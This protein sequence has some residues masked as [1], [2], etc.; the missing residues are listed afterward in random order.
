MRRWPIFL[1]LVLLVTAAVAADVQLKDNTVLVKRGPAVITYRDFKA[2]LNRLPEGVRKTVADDPERLSTLLNNLVKERLVAEQARKSRLDRDP[3]VQAALGLAADRVLA[4]AQM[5]KVVREGK[6]ADYESMAREY[7]LAHPDEFKE[8]ERIDVSHILIDTDDRTDEQA[9]ERAEEVLHK[10]KSGE[11]S[12]E[13]LVEQY[14]DEPSAK[15][16]HG[17]FKGVKRGKFVKPFENAAFALDKPG[18]ITGPVKTRFGYHLIRL[19]G[20]TPPGEQSFE[21]AKPA[22][23]KR[24]REKQEDRIRGQYIDRLIDANPLEADE[25]TIR[26]LRDQ[27]R[28]HIPP[29][30]K[31]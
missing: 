17:H 22:L 27:Y 31:Q 9:R 20:R 28:H 15:D 5:A 26:A 1:A 18:D 25:A 23:V 4:Q 7:Y 29:E 12:F 19:D 10:L 2:E 30:L 14:S 21:K 8:P 3:D 16:N 13:E 11:A 6:G 24:M